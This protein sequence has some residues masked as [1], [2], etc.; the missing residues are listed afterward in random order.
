MPT[1]KGTA[2]RNR[3]LDAAVDALVRGGRG[4]VNLDHVLAATRTS[5]GQLFHYFPGG[6][7]ELIR[8]A[9]ARQLERLAEEATVVLDSFD[10]WNR[11]VDGIVRLHRLQTRSDACEMAAV[12]GRVLDPDPEERTLVGASLRS[13]HRHMAEGIRT[14]RDTG[15]LRADAD[16]AE[17]AALFLAALEGGAVVDKA[18]GSLDYLEPALRAALAHLRSFAAPALPSRETAGPSAAS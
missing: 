9:T 15:Q 17:L 2:T 11:W 1:T 4:A 16:P 5:K 10:A 12:A 14:M 13:W 6:K 7:Q 18:T 3:I 8:V